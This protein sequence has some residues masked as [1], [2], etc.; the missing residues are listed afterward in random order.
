MKDILL[1]PKLE[2][3]DVSAKP[4]PYTIG[5]PAMTA[6][7]G[8]VHRLERDLQNTEYVGIKFTSVG[9]VSHKFELDVFKSPRAFNYAV[10][11]KRLPPPKYKKNASLIPEPTAQLT[12]S[13]VIECS[14]IGLIDHDEFTNIIQRLIHNY[15]LSG[16]CIIG[17]EKPEL[18]SVHDDASQKKLFRRLMPGFCLI[19]RR[20]LVQDAVG[21]GHDSLDAILSYLHITNQYNETS[22]QWESNRKEPGWLVPI[23][24]GFQGVTQPGSAENTRDANNTPHLFAEPVIT[25]GEFVMPYRIPKLDNM[26]WH[27]HQD[28][29]KNL[30]VC[31]QNEPVQQGGSNVY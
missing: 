20:D 2:V 3:E 15:R 1:I 16:G 21:K 4:S 28:S 6:W 25:M 9:V 27:Y 23:T 13:V 31:Q 19:E 29:V 17:F 5:F 8:F 10:K 11:G 26:L 18:Y 14:D 12:A 30:Y 24:T 7:M 22:K